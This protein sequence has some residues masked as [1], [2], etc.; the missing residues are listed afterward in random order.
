MLVIRSS[1]G[2]HLYDVATDSWIGDE[3]KHL[4][5]FCRRRVLDIPTSTP[6]TALAVFEAMR[7]AYPDAELIRR[8]PEDEVPYVPGTVY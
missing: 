2:E 3:S 7:E 4:N 8:H 6:D 5:L 1:K